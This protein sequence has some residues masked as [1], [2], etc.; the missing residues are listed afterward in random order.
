MREL[1]AKLRSIVL[2]NNMECWECE[3]ERDS[4]TL[5][6]C[7]IINETIA[8][9]ETASN[10]LSMTQL[11]MKGLEE[12]LVE[13]EERIQ[14]SERELANLKKQHR[15]ITHSVFLPRDWPEI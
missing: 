6:G 7:A 14:E 10:A 12:R 13:R 4:C 11:R 9:I 1:I 15:E 2:L 8:A 5:Y 3:Y